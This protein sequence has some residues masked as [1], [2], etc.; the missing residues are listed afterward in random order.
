MI[1]TPA[2]SL[3]L[4]DGDQQFANDL[5]RY[6]RQE[7]NLWDC[8]YDYNVVAVLGS[9]ST[10]KSTLLNALFNTHFEM[11]DKMSRKQTTKGIWMSRS[12]GENLLVMDVEGTDGRERGEDQDFERKSALFSLVT[13]SVLIMNLWENM[14]GLYN[15]ANMGLLRIVLEVN[16]KLFQTTKKD[17]TLL[18]F[19]IRDHTGDTPLENLSQ[20]LKAD[21]GKIWDGIPKPDNMKSKKITDFFDFAFTALPHKMLAKADF[22]EGVQKLRSWFYNKN[23]ANYVFKVP[24]NKCVPAV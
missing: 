7:W 1:E 4:I 8:G 2:A 15:G 12:K 21:L 11:M 22:E 16:L 14:V 18:L 5:E 10:G 19:V 9:Q 17:K 6:M 20:T 13:S 23:D 24:Y 3:Q